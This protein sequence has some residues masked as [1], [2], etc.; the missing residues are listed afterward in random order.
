M[1]SL[2]SLIAAALLIPTVQAESELPVNITPELPQFQANINGRDV[3]IK[4]NQDQAN[5]INPVYAKTSR[6][7][8]PFCIQPAKLA[9]G[10][11]T[12]AELEIIDYLDKI[13]KGD[14]SIMVIDS[15]TPS[16]VAKGTI[17]GSVNLPWTRISPREGATTQDIIKHMQEDFGVV[18]A[19]GKDSF[20]VDEAIISGLVKDIFDFS[21]AKTLV[22]F[23]N[24]IWCGQSP[25]NIRTL[26]NYGY[27]AE[28]IKWYRG[29]MQDWEILGLTTVKP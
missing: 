23:C 7:C 24:G 26:L 8:P 6:P 25:A 12:I 1:K 22:L 11:E 9:D 3:L 18:L 5:T 17:P 4:R 14:S 28:K 21:K 15:R 27:P 13:A 2:L 20:D 19:E 10:V 29:G 16:W